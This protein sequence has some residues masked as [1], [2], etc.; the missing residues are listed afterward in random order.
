MFCIKMLPNSQAEVRKILMPIALGDPMFLGMQDFDFFQI[1]SNFPKSNHFC[2][3]TA[4][5]LPKSNQICP[6]D[7][8]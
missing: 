2:P 1:E 6:K 5:I 8:Y 4:S 3:N 7:F